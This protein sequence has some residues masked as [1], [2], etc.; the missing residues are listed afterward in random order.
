[1]HRRIEAFRRGAH[2]PSWSLRRL[3]RESRA[4]M[5]AA[6]ISTRPI[7][8]LF[9]ANVEAKF[10]PLARLGK[11]ATFGVEVAATRLI[12]L[13]KGRAV[14]WNLKVDLLLFSGEGEWIPAPEL[15]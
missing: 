2:D 14:T 8:A 5:G 1:M 12:G 13:G 11:T 15:P 4:P 7:A 10:T 9:P 6:R 3:A